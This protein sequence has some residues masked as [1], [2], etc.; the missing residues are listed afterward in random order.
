MCRQVRGDCGSAVRQR[1]GKELSDRDPGNADEV[2][3]GRPSAVEADAHAADLP[4]ERVCNPGTE[5]A[6]RRRTPTSA[7]ERR[8]MTENRWMWEWIRSHRGLCLP[9][10]NKMTAEEQE[11]VIEVVRGCFG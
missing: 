7:A 10:D 11:R 5:M 2:Q 6:E 8:E 4:D 1:A 3:R 9:S